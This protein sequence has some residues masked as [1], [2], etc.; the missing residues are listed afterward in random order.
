MRRSS[1]VVSS[2]A[3]SSLAM[4]AMLAACHPPAAT[5]EPTP[6]AAP[7]QEPSPAIAAPTPHHFVGTLT[8]PSDPPRTIDWLIR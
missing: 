3:L 2:F 6:T 8:L 1:L 7:T 5:P 4:L